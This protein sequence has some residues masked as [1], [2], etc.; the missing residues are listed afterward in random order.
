M[1]LQTHVPYSDSGSSQRVVALQEETMLFISPI[2][3]F[4]IEG[5]K[6]SSMFS[7]LLKKKDIALLSGG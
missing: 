5:F 4:Y 1:R 2:D 6:K 3:I 7:N